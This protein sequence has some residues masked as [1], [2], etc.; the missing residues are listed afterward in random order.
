MKYTRA[1]KENGKV[2]V[3]FEIG[4]DEWETY[5]EKAYQKDKDKYKKEGF[6]QG[7][8][9]R[10]VLEG[11]Y[12]EH[13]FYETAFDLLF[14]DVYTQM[15]A[16][17]TDLEPVDYPE[18]DVKKFGK[19]GVVFSAN[20]VVYPDVVLGKYTGLEVKQEKAKV[21][22]AEVNTELNRLAERNARYEEKTDRA[23]RN[24]DVVEINYSG[25]EGGKKFEGGTAKDQELE[26]GS[27]SF[28]PGFEEGVVGMKVGETKN[29]NVTFPKEYHAKE[30]AGKPAVFEVEL[31]SI[32]EKV[33]PELN[34]AFAKEV[35]EKETL[36]ELKE[37][38][39][40]RLLKQKENSIEVKTENDLV[41]M[42]VNDAKVEIPD[43]MVERQLDYFVDD[44]AYRLSY[45][46][47]RFED[48]LQYIGKTMEDYRNMRREEAK[49]AVK[50]NIVL[51][52]IIKK[53]GI[54]VTDEEAEKHFLE[55]HTDKTDKKSTKVAM[56]DEQKKSIKNHIISEKLVE[57]IKKNNKIVTAETK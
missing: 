27:H 35:S 23:A 32:R 51:D 28:I 10:K 52:A 24:G 53:E 3:E 19:D 18:I 9:P 4:A 31:L 50:T 14:P 8:V 54:V 17:E 16:K 49:Q 33:L 44:F 12:G 5:V 55:H 22:A 11:T 1:K 56:T 7:K 48:Y 34:D 26:L 43:Q 30:L 36:A 40:T 29:I 15:L 21:L 37:D 6:R 38:I 45:Q 13:V 46:G 39:K 2:L 42:I 41:K 20:I 57:F 25:S 47:L